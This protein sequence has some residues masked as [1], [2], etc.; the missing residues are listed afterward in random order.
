MSIRS[1]QAGR[2]AP[3]EMDWRVENR[4]KQWHQAFFASQA[5]KDHQAKGNCESATVTLEYMER[6]GWLKEGDMIFDPMCGIGTFPIVAALRGYNALG[7]ELESR[8]IRDMIGYD[9]QL[10]EDTLFANETAHVEGS[11]ERF[12]RITEDV[13]KVGSIRIL[14]CDARELESISRDFFAFRADTHVLCS[15]PYTSTTEQ[16][17]KQAS[18]LSDYTGHKEHKYSETNIAVLKDSV[19]DREMRKVYKSLY[20]VL[21]PG[22][23][24]ALVTENFI[25][26][27]RV[28]LLDQLTMELMRE[29]GFI[30]LETK[31]VQIPE[32]S[33]L[34]R[35]N[36]NK[37]HEKKGLPLI[38]W[39]DITFYKKEE[40]RD[41]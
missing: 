37:H 21:R 39:E 2:Y 40:S 3:P 23:Y 30:Y 33:F 31:R 36:Y 1:I 29:A 28:V 11:I 12:L 32:V 22:S 38:D 34:K 24:V 13:K 14:Q 7:T 19:Y 27:A 41:G 6:Q 15:P 8:Y 17:K 9:E 18:Y 26:A 20:N 4:N 25:Q 5:L 35:I 10:S 16:S